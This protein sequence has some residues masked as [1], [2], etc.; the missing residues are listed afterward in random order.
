MKKSKV[1]YGLWSGQPRHAFTS[2]QDFGCHPH[3]AFRLSLL[4]RYIE[5]QGVRPSIGEIIMISPLLAETCDSSI[6]NQIHPMKRCLSVT[7]KVAE[8][9]IR[10]RPTFQK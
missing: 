10:H 7:H 9:T 1:D 6:I 2:P 5:Q 4:I 3:R 8:G